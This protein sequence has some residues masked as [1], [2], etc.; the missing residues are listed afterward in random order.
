MLNLFYRMKHNELPG[1]RCRIV[2]VCAEKQSAWKPRDAIGEKEEAVLIAVSWR[3]TYISLPLPYRLDHD[4]PK[5][6]IFF[7]FRAD[8]SLFLFILFLKTE[9]YIFSS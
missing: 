9:F 3:N 1:I 5:I 4:Y 2:H 6:S 8:N 7:I